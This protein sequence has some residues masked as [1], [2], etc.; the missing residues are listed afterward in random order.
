MGDEREAR[1]RG[2]EEGGGKRWG[3]AG[4]QLLVTGTRH[5]PTATA[6]AVATE[7]CQR[8]RLI[9]LSGATLKAA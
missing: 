9:Y 3:K 1:G 4:S 2:E 5:L 8:T 6:D 7:R